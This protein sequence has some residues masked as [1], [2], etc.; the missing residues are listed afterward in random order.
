MEIICIWDKCNNK[1]LMC[2]NPDGAWQAWDGSYD[3]SYEALVRRIE[4]DKEIFKQEESLYLTG[5]EPT[6]HPRFI[7]LL[8]YLKQSFPKHRVKILS[9]GRRFFYSSFVKEVLAS[10]DNLEIDV[11][12]YGA[13]PKTHDRITRSKGSFL[14]TKTGIE[15]LLR[16]KRKEQQIGLRFVI[17]ALSKVDLLNILELAEDNFKGLDRVVLVFMEIEA[18]AE[19]NFE[20]LKISYSSLKKRIDMILPYIGR[21]KELR[22]YHFPLC[23]IAPKLWPYAWKTLPADEVSFIKSCQKCPV[24]DLCVGIHKGY[25]EYIGG[26]EFRPPKHIPL[27]KKST[28][29]FKPIDYNEEK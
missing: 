6:I 7:D 10:V 13:S 29:C 4:K 5:G 11:S 24:K 12:L 19:K 14:Q 26:D 21:F 23:T 25:L 1:C 20:K 2:T 17:T 22:L 15:N 18:M 27:F 8:K 16:Q 28:N 3:Y 9:N